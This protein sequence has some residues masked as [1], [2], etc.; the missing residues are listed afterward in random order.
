MIFPAV[1]RVSSQVSWYSFVQL[2]LY[3][4]VNGVQL[5]PRYAASVGVRYSF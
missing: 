2:I 4:Y 5:A 3:Q 1:V